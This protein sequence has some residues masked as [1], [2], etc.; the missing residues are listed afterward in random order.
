[1]AIETEDG[2][3]WAEAKIK[4][5]TGGDRIAAR[6]M[7]Q[8]F[9]EYV[10]QF[11]LVVAG[12]HKPGLRN[13]DEAMRRRIHMIPFAVTIPES[14]RDHKLSEKLRTEYPGI[15]QWAIAG[16]LAWQR[17]GLNPP[18][19]VREATEGYLAAED[20]LGRWIEE[21]C[22]TAPRAWTVG[23]DLF[24]DWRKWCQQ[25]GEFVGSR[26]RF[27]QQMEAHGF[28]PSRTGQARGFTGVALR[29]DAVTHMTGCSI[30]DVPR[31]CKPQEG[32]RVTSVTAKHSVPIA[33]EM[34]STESRSKIGGND[35]T[36]T[37]GP[38]TDE[39]P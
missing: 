23:A 3:C 12:N 13:T 16:C 4:S 25:A 7:R 31:V 29:E 33:P 1:M 5:L 10:P 9:F 39:S 22:T 8:D 36:T 19:I 34:P 24:A 20:T 26:K 2:R 35:R 28:S 17:E 6:F 14:E 37:N 15:L 21:C 30:S 32:E 38:R 27:A 11:K 18:A